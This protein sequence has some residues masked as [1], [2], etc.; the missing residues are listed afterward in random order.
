MT[1]HIIREVS[2]YTGVTFNQMRSDTRAPGIVKARHISMYL[3][4]KYANMTLTAIGELFY[5][6]HDTVIHARKS[7]NDLM[8]SDHRY[9]NDVE[10]LD[11]TIKQ[12]IDDPISQEVFMEPDFFN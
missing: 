8:F 2:Q 4:A 3:M 9:R 12:F 11:E 10:I 1:D 5:R 6:G 7:V